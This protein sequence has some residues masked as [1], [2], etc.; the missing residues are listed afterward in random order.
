MHARL[1]PGLS[2]KAWPR[3]SATRLAC[4]VGLAS[5]LGCRGNAERPIPAPGGPVMPAAGR[6]D[7]D[8]AARAGAVVETSGEPRVLCRSDRDCPIDETCCPSGFFGVC[9]ALGAEGV[10]PAPD[11]ALAAPP[12]FKPQVQFQIF[13]EGDCR[14]EKCVSGRGARRLL[15]FP[16][17]LANTGD[18]D[19]LLALRG[20][21]GV[22]HVA[23]DDSSFLDDFLRYELIDA[24]GVRRAGGTGDINLTCRRD[25]LAQSTSPFDCE[26]LGIEAHSYRSFTGGDD[27]Q[28]VDITTVPPGQ[29]T[30]K[31]SVNADGQLAEADLGNNVLELPVTIPASDPLAPCEGELPA[32]VGFGEGVECGWSLIAGQVGASCVPG[33][34]VHLACTFCEGAYVP[35]ACPG[36]EPCS[37]AGSLINSLA[38]SS[39]TCFGESCEVFGQ[40]SDFEFICPVSGRYTLLGFPDVP[41]TQYELGVPTPPRSLSCQTLPPGAVLGVPLV[42]GGSPPLPGFQGAIPAPP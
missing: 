23:C 16:L 33:E 26:T 2:L 41:F 1:L 5:A 39:V 11:L 6:A 12:G 4:L 31:L 28:W 8:A 22:R 18:G 3:A 27:C 15:M 30:L 17:N 7:V 38:M 42:D 34:R 21:P 37:A 19:M 29:Y 25:Y 35:R 10:C 14:L 36:V 20:A 24:D 32:A 40:C 13:S 9:A